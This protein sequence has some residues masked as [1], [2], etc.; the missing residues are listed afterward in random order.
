MKTE[1]A[2]A[3][4]HVLVHEGGK[5][6]HPRDPGGRTN[7]GVTQATY[8]LYRKSIGKKPGDV[9][10]MTDAERDAIYRK[11]FWNVIEGDKLPPGLGY[12]IFDG[13]VNS[14]PSQ[15]VKWVQRAMGTRYTGK[16]D[17]QMGMM[18]LEAIIAFPDHDKLVANIIARRLEFLKNLK[19]WGTF[20]KGWKR[21]VDSVLATGQA[22][23]AGS[24]GPKVEYILGAEAKASIEDA[25]PLPVKAV[26]DTAT[27]VGGGTAVVAQTI[28]QSKD[29]LAQF[30]DIQFVQM[31]LL[32]LTVAGVSLAVV[33]L[34]YR[35]YAAR[36]ERNM[37]DA[38]DLDATPHRLIAA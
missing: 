36:K 28:D 33:G 27:G 24:V 17:G 7:Q 21:R 20:G 26:A 6:D 38:L 29:Q 23:A 11:R 30:S 5:I 12:T 18:T 32:L 13:A 16:I 8:N 14:G 22:W 35:W 34:V 37:T 2:K 31:V 4:K 19:T 9:Y 10:K 15:S 3:M 1:F 25:K